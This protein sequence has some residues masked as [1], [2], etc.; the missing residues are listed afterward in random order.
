MARI[1]HI[2]R[3]LLNWARWLAK[4]R[5]GG[6]NYASI[7]LTQPVVDRSGWD[8]ETP[9]SIDDA[10]ASLTDTAVHQLEQDLRDAIA[11]CYLGSGSPAQY[12]KRLGVALATVYARRDRAHQALARWFA[13][14]EAAAKVERQRVEHLQRLAAVMATE[15]ATHHAGTAL[16]AG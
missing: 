13:E 1:D 5:G 9:I 7:D 16:G 11:A 8:A 15:R 6:G 14:R 2:D 10:E 12:A 4:M 3:R